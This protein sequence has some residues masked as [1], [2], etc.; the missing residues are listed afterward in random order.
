MIIVF[1]CY[2]IKNLNYIKKLN[3]FWAMKIKLEQHS[4]LFFYLGNDQ[5]LIP[6]KHYH[7]VIKVV[8]LQDRDFILDSVSLHSKD[9]QMN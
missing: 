1:N 9:L 8:L 2:L 4:S 3:Y 5:F 6:I 7:A